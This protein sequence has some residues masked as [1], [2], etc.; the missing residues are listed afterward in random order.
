M[1]K[2]K[3]KEAIDELKESI[4]R[5]AEGRNVEISKDSLLDIEEIEDR[6]D[7]EARRPRFSFDWQKSRKGWDILKEFIP[8]EDLAKRK[9]ELADYLDKSQ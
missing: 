2:K 9:R 3:M 1:E 7:I 5:E 8:K 4:M 6:F